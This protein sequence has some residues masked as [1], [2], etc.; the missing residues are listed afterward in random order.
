MINEHDIND[1]ERFDVAP[2]KDVQDGSIVSLPSDNMLYYVKGRD[3]LSRCVRMY[4]LKDK[5]CGVPIF[6]SYEALV[7]TYVKRSNH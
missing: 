1:W 2:I 3:H 5:D 6:I 7:D 4:L